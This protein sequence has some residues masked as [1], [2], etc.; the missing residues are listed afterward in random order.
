MA[1]RSRFKE[2]GGREGE[3]ERAGRGAL[4]ALR[5]HL[6]DMK[7]KQREKRQETKERKRTKEEERGIIIYLQACMHE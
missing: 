3:R 5:G 6:T 2:G 1:G 7:S 4:T